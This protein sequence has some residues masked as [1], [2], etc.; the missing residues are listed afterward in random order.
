MIKLIEIEG[1]KS[2]GSPAQATPLDRLNFIVGANAAGKSNLIGALRF[3]KD[4]VLQNVEYA[5]NELGGAAEVRNKMPRQRSVEKPLRIKIV[6][7]LDF[8]I[9]AS[10]AMDE[11]LRW[12]FE[13]ELTLDLRRHAEEVPIILCEELTGSYASKDGERRFH[14][15]RDTD[16]VQLED[17]TVAEVSRNRILSIPSQDAAR[18]ALGVGFF[19]LPIV[20]LRSYI[21]NWQFFNISPW[22]ARLPYKEGP[23][24]MLGP[25][26]ENLAVVL[27]QI[28][29]AGKRELEA[30]VSALRTAVP[31]FRGIRTS[32]LPVEGKQAFQV[33][34]DRIRT[35]VNPSAASDGTIRLLALAVITAWVS[36]SASLIAIEE[37]ENGI[38]PHLAEQLVDLLRQSAARTQ[39]LVTTHEPDFLDYLVP[40]EVLL[41][42]KIDGLTKLHHATDIEQIEVYRRTFRLGELWV[43]GS[44]GGVP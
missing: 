16:T 29:K 39:V 28:E 25:S 14:L 17:P 33:L 44:L 36:R 34:E 12:H 21:E 31:G 3:L 26:G 10:H 6:V 19:S 41:V 30:V 9:E 32:R 1:F 4:A 11:T 38:H 18:L 7:D 20:V 35:A 15:R 40:G 8:D 23:D 37:P 27:K 24:A 13:Y 5:V 22:A 42:D 2:F 43:Q